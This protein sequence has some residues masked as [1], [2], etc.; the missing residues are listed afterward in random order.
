MK[1][2]YLFIIILI[3]SMA[4]PNAFACGGDGGGGAE[5]KANKP[6]TAPYKFSGDTNKNSHNTRKKRARRDPT[7]LIEQHWFKL[8]DYLI[9][10]SDQIPETKKNTQK[11]KSNQKA[12]ALDKMIGQKLG[13]TVTLILMCEPGTS[14]KEALNLA[15]FLFCVGVQYLDEQ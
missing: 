7:S 14:P 15:T 6:A 2:I 4:S 8:T 13:E 12:D 9:K 11:L 1:T 10:H 3:L 5:N